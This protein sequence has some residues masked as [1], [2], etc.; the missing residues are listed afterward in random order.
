MNTIIS[1]KPLLAVL[2]SIL[3]VPLILFSG[4]KPNFREGWTFLAAFIKFG[5]VLSLL[6]LVLDGKEIV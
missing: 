1:L 2:V 5:L 6:P 4:K 3:A